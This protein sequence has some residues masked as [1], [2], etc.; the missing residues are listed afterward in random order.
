MDVVADKRKQNTISETPERSNTNTAS[1]IVNPPN[2]VSVSNRSSPK[3]KRQTKLTGCWK[4]SEREGGLSNPQQ[5]ART[6][7]KKEC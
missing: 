4:T 1:N 2:L 3:S 5:K 7:Q 6:E